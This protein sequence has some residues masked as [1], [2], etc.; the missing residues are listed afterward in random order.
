MRRG[1]FMSETTFG[2]LSMARLHHRSP[3][4]AAVPRRKQVRMKM[5]VPYPTRRLMFEAFSTH[6]TRAVLTLKTNAARAVGLRVPQAPM[7]RAYEALR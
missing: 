1:S 5:H 3:P 2:I 6:A 7:R 4:S